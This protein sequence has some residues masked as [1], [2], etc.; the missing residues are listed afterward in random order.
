MRQK[1]QRRHQSQPADL[2]LPQGD[3]V[4]QLKSKTSDGICLMQEQHQ[5]FFVLEAKTARNKWQTIQTVYPLDDLPT[6]YLKRNEAVDAK[7]ALKTLLLG[8]WKNRVKKYPIRVRE[9]LAGFSSNIKKM[10]IS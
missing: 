2:N 9:T 1:L 3:A 10:E 4:T 7:A 5:S 6:F 8:K